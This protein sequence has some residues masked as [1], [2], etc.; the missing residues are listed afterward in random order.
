MVGAAGYYGNSQAGKTNGQTDVYGLNDPYTS[1][2]LNSATT[3]GFTS[4]NNVAFDARKNG[5]YLTNPSTYGQPRE[6]DYYRF[7]F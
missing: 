6:E 2:T 7:G 5:G 1:P 4:Q 3:K